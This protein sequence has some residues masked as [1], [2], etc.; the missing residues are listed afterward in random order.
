MFSTWCPQKVQQGIHFVH[1]QNQN[2]PQGQRASFSTKVVGG[3]GWKNPA[4][5]AS[6]LWRGCLV[7]MLTSH[8]AQRKGRGR[9]SRQR[10]TADCLQHCWQMLL[11]TCSFATVV[12]TRRGLSALQ[13]SEKRLFRVLQLEEAWSDAGASTS[14]WIASPVS[15]SACWRSCRSSS[16]KMVQKKS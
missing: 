14:S 9:Q 11:F 2:L 15:V 10:I 7:C 13:L 1:S 8:P 6:L 4:V 16:D 5:L 12:L 3:I